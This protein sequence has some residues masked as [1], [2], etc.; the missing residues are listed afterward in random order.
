MGSL[1]PSP[2]SQAAGYDWLDRHRELL[3]RERLHELFERY[4][5][6]EGLRAEPFRRG[7]D[8]LADAGANREPGDRGFAPRIAPDRTDA[9]TLHEPERG[10]GQVGRLPVSAARHVA[11]E[12]AARGVRTRGAVGPAGPGHRCERGRPTAAERHPRRRGDGFDHRLRSRC[13]AP[14]PGLPLAGQHPPVPAAPVHRG[15]LD[16]RDHGADRAR[17]ELLQRVRRHDDH[18]HRRRLRGAHGPSLARD[19]LRPRRSGGRASGRGPGRDRQ[20][21][22]A[23]RRLDQRRFRIARPVALPGPALHGHRRHPRRRR[24]RPG[25]DHAAAGPGRARPAA[26]GERRR[27]WE[28]G[29]PAR[30]RREAPVRRRWG[31]GS[32]DVRGSSGQAPGGLPFP[33][34]GGPHFAG[35]RAAR[36]APDPP[37]PARGRCPRSGRALLCRARAGAGA[38]R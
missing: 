11:P 23:R 26:R 17:H 10:R 38:G 15:G 3:A 25:L 32:A 35:R 20:G 24:D 29:H 1:I 12:R 9:G 21:D 28:R 6:E 36:G 14:V 22:R 13:P 30:I 19:R 27:S 34:L 33:A 2:A 31:W 5:T 16:A 18:R 4:A 7:I 37:G 8:L